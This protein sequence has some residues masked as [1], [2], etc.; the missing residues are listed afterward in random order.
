MVPIPLSACF[1]PHLRT[2][3]PI[4]VPTQRKV[5]HNW[6]KATPPVMSNEQS[7]RTQSDCSPHS[8][9]THTHFPY[10]EDS[11]LSLTTPEAWRHTEKVTHGAED[12][13][14]RRFSN[15]LSGSSKIRGTSNL[16]ERQ[17]RW[18]WVLRQWLLCMLNRG[19]FG[20][21]L[22]WKCLWAELVPWAT[23][24]GVPSKFSQWEQW[25]IHT[26]NS[27]CRKDSKPL[28]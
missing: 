12:M 28:A 2:G 1:T 4:Q 23:S 19:L 22:L 7:R 16:K 27:L 15:S 18:K 9:P 8:T 6:R 10:W 3:K 26:R 5:P 11:W 20:Y 14:L 17:S 24:V 21:V 13:V 25:E